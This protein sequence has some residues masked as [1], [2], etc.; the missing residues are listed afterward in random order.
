MPTHG[1]LLTITQHIPQRLN[2][3]TLPRLSKTVSQ[4]MLE[5]RTRTRESSCNS[6]DSRDRLIGRWVQRCKMLEREESAEAGCER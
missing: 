6:L 4:F 1:V 3:S 2:S 5:Q